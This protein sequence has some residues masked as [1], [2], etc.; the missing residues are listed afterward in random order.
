MKDIVVAKDATS[1]Q[2]AL[3]CLRAQPL[4]HSDR[5]HLVR[6]PVDVGVEEI[7]LHTGDLERITVRSA[8][9]PLVILQFSHR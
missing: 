8:R 9:I 2:I 5:R 6:L 4:N 3:A 7:V 1:A